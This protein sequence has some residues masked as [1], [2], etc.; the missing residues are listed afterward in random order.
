[1]II[2]DSVRSDIDKA[3]KDGLSTTSIVVQIM[4]EYGPSPY[5]RVGREYIAATANVKKEVL[6]Q[7]TKS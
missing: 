4:R 6:R 1:M 7:R 5:P 3:I 2:T